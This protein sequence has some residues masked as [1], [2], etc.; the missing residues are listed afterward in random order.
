MFA[1]IITKWTRS[2]LG[3]QLATKQY[4]YSLVRTEP[5]LPA[6]NDTQWPSMRL[7]IEAKVAD[8]IPQTV[9]I[10]ELMVFYA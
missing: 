4:L 1:D 9:L 2:Y 3:D 7:I 6:T 5:L 8:E 10:R